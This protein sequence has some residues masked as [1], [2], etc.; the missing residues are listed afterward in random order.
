MLENLKLPE[1]KTQRT[2]I[3][4]VNGTEHRAGART[5]LQQQDR[6]EKLR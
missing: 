1:L 5:S 3:E 6:Q 2:C 4:P